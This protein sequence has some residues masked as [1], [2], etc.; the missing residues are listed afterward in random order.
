M[1]LKWLALALVSGLVIG[2]GLGFSVSRPKTIT[3][4]PLPAARQVDGSLILERKP[5]PKAKPKQVIPKGAK[6]ERIIQSEIHLNHPTETLKLD[7]TLVSLSD[8]S[9]RVIASSPDGTVTG[10]LDI[11]VSQIVIPSSTPWSAG[12]AY[13]PQQKKYGGFV[14]YRKGAFIATTVVIGGN[15]IV[16]AGFNF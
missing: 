14:A 7:L 3:E 15:I 2:Y 5:D 1:N 4:K 8:G 10:G 9:K 16:G 12:V 13:N 6:V 11:P